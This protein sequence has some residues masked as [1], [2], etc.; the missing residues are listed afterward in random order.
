MVLF[1]HVS[2]S[3]HVAPSRIRCELALFLGSQIFLRPGST[4][5][6]GYLEFLGVMPGFSEG[7]N[8]VGLPNQRAYRIGYAASS[9]HG[10]S[11]Q[12]S[13]V[14]EVDLIQEIPTDAV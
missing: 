1:L 11:A 10:G 12:F 13:L 8:S 9:N 2:Y 4:A 7:D 3:G 5:S 14:T 6:S